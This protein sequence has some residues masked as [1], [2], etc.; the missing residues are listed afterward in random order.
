MGLLATHSCDELKQHNKDRHVRSRIVVKLRDYG[1]QFMP[2]SWGAAD[3]WMDGANLSGIRFCPYC[4]AKL[5][6][7][8]GV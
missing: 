6:D 5:E 1:V 4:G 7:P 3:H 2:P 8:K